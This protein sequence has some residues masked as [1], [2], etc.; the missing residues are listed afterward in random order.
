M[1]NNVYLTASILAGNPGFTTEAS[2]TN[3]ERKCEMNKMNMPGFTAETSLYKTSGHYYR[4]GTLD[5][6]KGSGEVLPQLPVWII[7]SSTCSI[8]CDKYL[9][10]D[11]KTGWFSEVTLCYLKCDEPVRT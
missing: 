1:W 8:Q 5:A 11:D 6:N 9:S 2:C 10:Y 7:G 4:L 3:Q